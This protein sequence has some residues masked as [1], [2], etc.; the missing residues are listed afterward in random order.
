MSL[1]SKSEGVM[2]DE[3]RDD[4]EDDPLSIIFLRPG[5]VAGASNAGV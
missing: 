1:E 3:S 5:D 2:D 4:D